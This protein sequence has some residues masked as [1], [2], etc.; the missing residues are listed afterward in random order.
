M[1]RAMAETGAAG[2]PQDVDDT[3]WYP[4]AQEAI[5]SRIAQGT[6]AAFVIDVEQPTER[7]R[8]PRGGNV[9]GLLC[10]DA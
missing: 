7:R 3:S 5:A 10:C 1:F 8:E 4:A 2:R 6:L 9:A